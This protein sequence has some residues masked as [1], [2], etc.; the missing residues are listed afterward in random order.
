MVARRGVAAKGTHHI[1]AQDWGDS[2]PGG[3]VVGRA[4]DG[5][6]VGEYKDVARE[7]GE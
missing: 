3:D 5:V 1:G 4:V 7:P 6:R 2:G